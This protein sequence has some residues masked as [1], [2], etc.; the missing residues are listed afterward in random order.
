VFDLGALGL[1]D[2]VRLSAVLRAPTPATSMESAA[3]TIVTFLRENLV[4]KDTGDPSCPLVRCYRTHRY[5]LLEPE[6]QEFAAR[7]LR[8]G[9]DLDTLRCLTLLATAGERPEWND[10]RR[11]AGHQAIPLPSP[12]V[13]RR[14]PMIHELLVQLGV[15]VEHVVRP[16]SGLL[17][18]RRPEPFNV[19]HVPDALGSPYV[20]AQ[21]DFV[22]PYG[23]A[24][25]L[26]FG[27][28][29]PDGE[30]YAVI[31]FSRTPIS[32][33]V[34]EQF[35][36]VT[37][38]VGIA[39]LPYL[40]RVFDSAPEAPGVEPPVA[41]RAAALEQLLEVREEVLLEQS[42][43]IEQ[44]LADLEDRAAELARS[45]AVLGESEA[46][47]AAV[48]DAALDAIVTVDAGNRIVE[49]N[50]AAEAM[51]GIPRADAIGAPMPE[52]LVPA[53]LRPAHHAGF[54]RH[55]L[56][57]EA[58][59]LGTRVEIVALRAGGDEFPVELTVTRIDVDGPP[60][61]TAHIRDLTTLKRTE[62][63]LRELADTLQAG[64]L[65]PRPPV[66]PGVDI[67]THYR[68]G[69]AGVRVGG[70][71]YDV[72]K[73]GDEWGVIIGDVCGKGAKAASVTM[74]VRYTARSAA[75]HSA[76]PA[77]V[78]REINAVLVE[79]EADDRYCSAVFARLRAGAGGVDVVACGG[80]H[81]APF[82]VR[83]AGGVEPVA[84]GGQLV[85]L[86][87]EYEGA[88]A[89][90]RLE[91]G[92]ALVLYTDGVTEA[93]G[94]GGALYGDER[95][96]AVLGRCAGL[97]AHAVVRAVMD[98][99]ADWTDAPGDDVALVVLRPQG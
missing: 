73:V 7:A 90:L 99:L 72:F 85:G 4:D 98:D 76:D 31:L 41:W 49:F 55:L 43:R 28:L 5:A 2:L 20:P 75:A 69:G 56:T 48:L 65:P 78:I 95:L 54:A 97:R 94:P 45:R 18:T 96:A 74:L 17:V 52:L 19:F 6:L 70:D 34:A 62:A 23:I 40:Y 58:R 42:L 89:E 57:G 9:E 36:T 63:E 12:D 32:R 13:V 27:G 35:R 10:R 92:D 77:E 14:S 80:G 59:I 93:R 25:V 66:V 22:V 11:S 87:E 86:F 91:P 67:A 50:P 33:D 21:D 39:L 29:L 26:G 53:R 8:G 51:F 60:M 24:S 37:L 3:R 16:P 71:F 81:P 38:A 44:A 83:A 82:V 64:L 88:C 61:F 1:S 68:A 47:K 15:D 79:D 46:R 30:L 84:T